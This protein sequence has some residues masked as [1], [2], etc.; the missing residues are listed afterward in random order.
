MRKLFTE[1][2]KY[3]ILSL[4]RYLGDGLFYPFFALYLKSRN[5][6]ESNIGFILSI[7]P[8]LAIIMNPIYSKVC[9][10]PRITKNVLMII[11]VIEGVCIGL[12][13]FFKDFYVISAITLLIAIFG[14]CHY[15]LMDALAAL[16]CN[17]AEINYSSIRM[18]G[19]VAIIYAADP[20]ILILE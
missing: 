7:A 3:K 13:A 9:K 16:Y 2:N 19:S 14:S 4:V 10:S 17:H 20:N 18:F 12:I 1:T 6:T 11:T 15:G 5:L 8:L